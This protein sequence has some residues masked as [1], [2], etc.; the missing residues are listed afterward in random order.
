MWEQLRR[1][2][3][4]ESPAQG[5]FL[6]S[7]VLLPLVAVSLRWRGFRATK[8][9]LQK[10]LPKTIAEQNADTPRERAALT[11]RMVHAAGR[12]GSFHPSCL[13]KSL[14]LWWLLGRQGISSSLRIGVRREKEAFEAHAWVEC[15]GAA[16][17]EPEERHHHYLAFDEAL[18]SL[19]ADEE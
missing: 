16:L 18:S 17:N 19:P 3:A 12:Y 8:I 15:E 14:T 11:V 9:T 7:L 2:K 13:A 1:F 10:F 6:R 4:L 5:L